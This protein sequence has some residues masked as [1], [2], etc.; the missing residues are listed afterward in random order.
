[1]SKGIGVV[2]YYVLFYDL[3]VGCCYGCINGNLIVINDVVFCLICLLMW[4]GFQ[5]VDQS[6]VVEVFMCILMLCV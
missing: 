4:V 1:M 6:C 3:L 5:E 2:F